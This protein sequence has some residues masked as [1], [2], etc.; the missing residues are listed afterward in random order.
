MAQV[1]TFAVVVGYVV[2][3]GYAVKT[4][5]PWASPGADGVACCR[6]FAAPGSTAS[7]FGSMAFLFCTHFVL[8]PIMTASRASAA[9]EPGG[10]E[11]LACIAFGLAALINGA[12][13]AV[14]LVYFGPDVSS[15]VLNEIASESIGFT[16]TKVLMCVD[17]MCSFPLVFKAASQIVEDSLGLSGGATGAA[18]A[19]G[20]GGAERALKDGEASD[21]QLPQALLCFPSEA[22]SRVL[23]RSLLVAASVAISFIGDF[24]AIIS[25]VGSLSLASLAFVLP[26]I[27]ALHSGCC[28]EDG[29][30]R[31][32]RAASLATLLLGLALVGAGTFATLARI[33]EAPAAPTR[34]GT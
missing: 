8:F 33:F 7:A 11:L 13:G 26:P 17:L 10:F 2:T 20:A 6:L 23:V 3:I 1:G 15:I 14:G 32:R 16:I 34:G 5:K 29:P 30:P 12:F 25:I 22:A 21:L 4:R 31:L 18:G 24:G 19:A 9:R 27:M 28:Q